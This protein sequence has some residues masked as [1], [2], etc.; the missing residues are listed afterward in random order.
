MFLFK[1]PDSGSDKI[2]AST[3][4][5]AALVRSS[6]ERNKSYEQGKDDFL[7]NFLDAHSRLWKGKKRQHVLDVS[8]VDKAMFDVHFTVL[9]IA[10]D[11]H[12]YSG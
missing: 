10:C 3:S 8:H 4:N 12:I 11:A 2:I 7:P 1:S 5:H 6:D 9:V